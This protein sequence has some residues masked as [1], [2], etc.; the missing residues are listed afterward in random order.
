[1]AYTVQISPTAHRLAR[2]LP[3]DVRQSIVLHAKRLATK[4]RIG[5]KLKGRLAFLH[6]YHFS[7]KGVPYRI[8]YEI[9]KEKQQIVSGLSRL[10]RTSIAS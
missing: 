10:A 4:P 2:K 5:A 3:K 6:S 8:I 1:M 7:Y 9:S